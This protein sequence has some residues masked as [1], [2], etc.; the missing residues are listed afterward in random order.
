MDKKG[1]LIIIA[2][3]SWS[4][5]STLGAD[6]IEKSEWKFEYLKTYTTR[7]KRDW[8]WDSEYAFV[9]AQTYNILR[10]EWWEYR[11]HDEIY[12]NYY[13]CDKTVAWNALEQGK[14]VV[15]NTVIEGDLISS[16]IQNYSIGIYTTF[17]VWVMIDAQTQQT[18]LT[19]ARPKHEIARVLQD[20]SLSCGL[21]IFNE[22]FYP[23]WKLEDDKKSFINLFI[24][25]F[26]Y[27]LD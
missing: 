17:V 3:N 8:E 5:K 7:P 4:W 18:R 14:N 13:G 21:E 1:T 19:E 11:D 15:V 26:Y 27:I 22:V 6:L 10:Q 9:D 23:S 25:L 24:N 20:K 16:L 12:W 2:W